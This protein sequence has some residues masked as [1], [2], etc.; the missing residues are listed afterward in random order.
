MLQSLA[1]PG[2][3]WARQPLAGSYR[4]SREARLA[5][6]GCSALRLRIRADFGWGARAG[7]WAERPGSA[8]AVVLG[9]GTN[10]RA[11]TGTAER[12]YGCGHSPGS[13]P[14][15]SLRREPSRAASKPQREGAL[16]QDTVAAWGNWPPELRPWAF[17]TFPFLLRL[18]WSLHLSLE[19]VSLCL[20][21]AVSDLRTHP[22]VGKTDVTIALYHFCLF[23]RFCPLLGCFG[24][25]LRIGISWPRGAAWSWGEKAGWG[26]DC[27]RS[28]AVCSEL[29]FLPEELDRKDEERCRELP[30][31]PPTSLFQQSGFLVDPPH[32]YIRYILAL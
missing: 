14:P 7:L 3:L 16:A 25:S 6:S 32:R 13:P 4:N 9:F 8:G 15:A 12:A 24:K 18:L 31:A 17:Q 11:W 30:P 22:V 29:I 10:S 1:V 19:V 5:V 26:A 21:G 2:W 23:P 28:T 27:R 20:P